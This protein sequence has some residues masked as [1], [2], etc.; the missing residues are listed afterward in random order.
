[1]SIE[2]RK[3]INEFLNIMNSAKKA[4]AALSRPASCG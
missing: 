3:K 2:K 1:M 4:P